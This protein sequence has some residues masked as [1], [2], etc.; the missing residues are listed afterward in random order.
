MGPNLVRGFAPAGIGPRDI[1]VNPQQNALGGTTY[2]GGTAEVQFPI[3]GI[4]KEFGMRGAVF[5]DAGTLFGY[6]GQTNFANKVP[7]ATNYCP[8]AGSAT[9]SWTYQPTCINV[10]DSSMIRSAV[11][12]SL[13]WTS[14]L[15]PIRFDWA[16]P[17]SK[18]QYD[19]T[20]YFRFSGGTS[21]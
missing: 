7:G 13:L 19:Q 9:T 16:Y 3:Y 2:F 5:A 18:Q 14:P 8:P 6:E 10:I 21:F 4:P 15:G 11:G 17:L 20:Q 1:T 12:V